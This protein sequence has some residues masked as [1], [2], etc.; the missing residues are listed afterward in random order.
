M[1]AA[2]RGRKVMFLVDVDE[3]TLTQ[4]TRMIDTSVEGRSNQ[5]G[6]AASN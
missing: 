6:F 2:V 1:H 3:L 4:M 5:V